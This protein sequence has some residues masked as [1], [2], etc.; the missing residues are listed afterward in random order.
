LDTELFPDGSI[1]GIKAHAQ[2]LVFSRSTEAAPVTELEV[3]DSY[4][5]ALEFYPFDGYLWAKLAFHLSRLEG[6]SAKMLDALDSAMKFARNDYHTFQVLLDI[7]IRDWPRF[8]CIYKEQMISVVH[9]SLHVD[10][11]LLSRWSAERGGMNIEGLVASLMTFYNFDPI[12]AAN[13]VNICRRKQGNR[14][15]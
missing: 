5:K 12:W 10:D 3:R 1:S 9:D 14:D 8:D 11:R 4:I 6:V 7:A 13:E 2:S 15:G